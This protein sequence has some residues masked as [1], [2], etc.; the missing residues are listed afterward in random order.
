MAAYTTAFAELLTN[1]VS[2]LEQVLNSLE[3]AENHELKSPARY[4]RWHSKMVDYLRQLCYGFKTRLL[5]RIAFL[6]QQLIHRPPATTLASGSSLSA[7][8]ASKPSTASSVTKPNQPNRPPD[9]PVS[10][11]AAALF[12][13]ELVLCLPTHLSPRQIFYETTLNVIGQAESAVDANDLKL[14]VSH[15]KLCSA[16]TRDW[17]QRISAFSGGAQ[18]QQ[19]QQNGQPQASTRM[20]LLLRVQGT[21]KSRLDDLSA[22][23]AKAEADIATTAKLTQRLTDLQEMVEGVGSEAIALNHDIGRL[24]K[25]TN[26]ETPRRQL[27]RLRLMAFQRLV[28]IFI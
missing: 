23:M 3:K 1:F 15:L 13:P 20:K 11:K 10:I 22:E 2:K 24:S 12:V 21:L 14:A 6:P 28:L 19:P 27:R 18:D 26:S 4:E 16:I 9:L 5:E 25:E 7:A 17:L 8:A